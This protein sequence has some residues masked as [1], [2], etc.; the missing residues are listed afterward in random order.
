MVCSFRRYLWL[1]S[2]HQLISK[3]WQ[4]KRL[5]MSASV[6]TRELSLKQKCLEIFQT[7]IN[8]VLPQNIIKN[9]ICMEGNRL[10]IQNQ[11]FPV[12]NNVYLAGFGK[13][14]MGMAAAVEQ[15]LGDH[16]VQGVISVPLGIQKVLRLAGKEEM[17]LR[18]Q[19]KIQ[20]QEGAQ[21]NLPDEN[22][23]KAAKRIHHLAEGLTENDLLLV[24]ISGGGSALL[25]APIP[26]VTLEEKH[27]LT[28][29]L[30]SKGATIQ[31]LN[32]VRK[33]LSLL[34]GGGLAR[35][36]YPA[37]VVSLILSDIIGDNLEFIA[38]GPTI[39]NKQSKEDSCKIL[40]KYNLLSSMPGNV[41]EVLSQPSTRM[42][43]EETQDYAHVFN[44][45]VGSNTIALEAAKCKSESSGY[46]TSI[47]STGVSGDVT[48]VARLFSLL[49]RYACSVLVVH[50]SKCAQALKDEML[51][52]IGSLELPDFRL[53]SCLELLENTL[54]S[55]KPLCLLAGGETTVQLQGRG[56]GGRNQEMALRV[57]LELH[58]AK[59]KTLH[60][61][62][63]KHEIV[64]LSGGTD[65]QD[66]P[67]EAAGGF[68]YTEMVENAF[69]EGLNVEDFLNNND[70]FTFFSKF[71]K[72]AD[73]IMT[74]LTSTN[75]MDI[76]AIIIQPKET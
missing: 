24:L 25:P 1:R 22:A 74:G 69:R 42:Y 50:D 67:T 27:Y 58:Q 15:I 62:F 57:A 14:V 63:A 20:A 54:S 46:N 51:Q 28:K 4:P 65:G 44:F 35:T 21:H 73:L 68:A 16:L 13:A 60:D 39:S 19:T 34:K 12:H 52:I 5:K 71:N 56:K 3:N 47:L 75:V 49:I 31:E 9:N 30:A 43:Q 53:D 48:I 2:N 36:A 11:S 64:F 18:P 29:Q 7:A 59:S 6:I 8:S 61:P 10:L 41:K 33:S 72:G 45:I 76:Q 40:S 66:G 38:S 26:P 23:L 37:Q 55:G 17:L 70:S 32:T